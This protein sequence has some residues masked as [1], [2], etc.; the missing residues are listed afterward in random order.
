MISFIRNTQNRQIHRN[1]KQIDG[2]QGLGVGVGRG[3]EQMLNGRNI[4][5]GN[6]RNILTGQLH[7][8]VKVLKPTKLFA[9]KFH[10]I[11]VEMN[12]TSIIKMKKGK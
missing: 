1:R 11:K 10:G 12:F 4:C 5:F 8:I 9:C 3:G 6:D 7:N 2:Y